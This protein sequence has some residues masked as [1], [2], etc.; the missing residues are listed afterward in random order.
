MKFLDN[1]TKISMSRKALFQ[2]FSAWKINISQEQSTNFSNLYF[3]QLPPI[4]WSRKYPYRLYSTF[5]YHPHPILLSVSLQ[6]HL[7]FE[8]MNS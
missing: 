3:R 2:K 6:S 5:P 8:Q 4:R 7:V 1:P